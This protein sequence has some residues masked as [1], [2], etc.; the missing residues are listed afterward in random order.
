MKKINN[1]EVKLPKKL[2]TFVDPKNIKGYDMFPEKHFNLFICSRK[3]SGKSVLL[4][5][6]LKNKADKDTV[7]LVFSPTA[8]NKDKVWKA[9]MQ[10]ELKNYNITF[11]PSIE[12]HLDAIKQMLMPEEKEEKKE[13]VDYIRQLM[14]DLFEKKGKVKEPEY[15]IVLDD[16]GNEACDKRLAEL[17][18]KNR[19]CNTTYIVSSQYFNDIHK[20][21]RKQLDFLLLLKGHK[22]DKLKEIHTDADIGID[23]DS[24]IELYN[25]ATKKD[26]S[27][28]YIDNLHHKFRKGFDLEYPI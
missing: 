11:F 25:D 21:G 5:N 22:F 6:I 2:N 19:H 1:V 27:F 4:I 18:K 16:L 3:L 13:N 20:Q 14:F 28:L 10:D 9:A 7:I 24:F 8:S 17:M 15:I 26:Y 23:L 12:E